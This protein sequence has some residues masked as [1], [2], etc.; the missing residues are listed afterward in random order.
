MKSLRLT[1]QSGV[2]IQDPPTPKVLLPDLQTL[3]LVGSMEVRSDYLSRLFPS[4]ERFEFQKQDL[5][6]GLIQRARVLSNYDFV[7]EPN[8][9]PIAAAC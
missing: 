9:N 6:T 3:E 2:A 8:I 1:M 4:L 5:I 7:I